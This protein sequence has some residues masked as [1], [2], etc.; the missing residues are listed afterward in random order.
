MFFF[1]FRSNN[2]PGLRI[3]C[4]KLT[5]FAREK[6]TWFLG[7]EIDDRRRLLS[8]VLAGRRASWKR[9]NR[10]RTTCPNSKH[11]EKPLSTHEFESR[12]VRVRQPK[13]RRRNARCT[14]Q[15]MQWWHSIDPALHAV[16]VLV[17]PVPRHPLGCL[18][19][20]LLGSRTVLLSTSWSGVKWR[21]RNEA[22]KRQEHVRRRKKK[23][24]AS[25]RTARTESKDANFDAPCGGFDK[26][27]SLGLFFFW[28]Q[29]TLNYCLKS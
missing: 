22:D 3:E 28:K 23:V 27:S 5:C 4:S 16:Y 29:C 11:E 6:A 15:R 26:F 25:V 7:G 13:L 17:L 20:F 21:L 1:P 24:S 8:G 2:R 18:K 9:E 12:R 19:A 10:S 14:H